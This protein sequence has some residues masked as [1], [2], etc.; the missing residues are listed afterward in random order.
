MWGKLFHYTVDAMLVTTV[1]AGIKR[2]TGLQP[3]TSKI[4]NADV[5]G[6]VEKY[7]QL[8][9]RVLDESLPYMKV[10]PFFEDEN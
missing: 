9:E 5:R 4:E 7:L 8:G 3:A 2:N 6:Y 1:L 10:S